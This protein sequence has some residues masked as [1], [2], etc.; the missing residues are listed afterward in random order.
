MTA[1]SATGSPAAR[2]SRN[3]TSSRITA[4]DASTGRRGRHRSSSSPMTRAPTARADSTT[5]QRRGAVELALGQDRAQH[6][7][8]GQHGGLVGR[9]PEHHQHHPAPRREL[10]PAVPDVLPDAR[11][12]LD[13]PG[14]R[15]NR[16][17][18]TALT[19]NDRPSTA[20]AQPADDVAIRTPATGGPAMEAMLREVT[21]SDVRRLQL[22][23]HHQAGHQPDRG[24][25]R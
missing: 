15:G 2:A 17:T 5:A 18:R 3:G 10:R 19:R 16:A 11:P 13:P 8:R 20:S 9:E 1:T 12:R 24:R 23:A 6:E 14:E 7:D 21:R 22:L 4:A 25:A